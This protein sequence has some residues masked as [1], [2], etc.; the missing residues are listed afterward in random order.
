MNRG[1]VRYLKLG[2]IVGE[3][4][5]IEGLAYLTAIDAACPIGEP[6]GADDGL[7]VEHEERAVGEKAAGR[8]LG[9]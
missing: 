4:A 8:L 6:F 7:D 5:P 1:T 2:V 9:A 3:Q